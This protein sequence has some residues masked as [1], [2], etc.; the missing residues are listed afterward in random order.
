VNV[1][2]RVCCA[3]RQTTPAD[4]G[5]KKIS[6][7]ESNRSYSNSQFTVPLH[8]YSCRCDSA[9]WLAWLLAYCIAD[10]EF[11]IYDH[12]ANLKATASMTLN[13]GCLAFTLKF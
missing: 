12:C 13:G 10:F 5:E 11:C 8:F 3:K 7:I 2:V 4:S 6:L 1:D 9:K